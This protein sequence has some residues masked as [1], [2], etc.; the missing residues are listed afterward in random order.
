MSEHLGCEG[1]DLHELLVPQLAAHRAEDAGA[2]RVHLVV[3]EH[4]GVLVEADVAAVGTALLLLHADDD[5]LHDLALLDGRAGDGVLDGGDEDVADAGVAPLGAAEHADAEDLLG[6]AVVRD[7]KWR[8]SPA[9]S[10]WPAPG[11]L[12]GASAS[13]WTR[14]GSPGPAPCRRPW[15]RWPRRGRRASSCAP[16][17]SCRAG[18]ACGS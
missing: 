6:P 5:A 7:P 8:D 12:R 10:S 15:R 17:S 16:S 18:A 1:D 13:A 2:P 3:D 4:G 14:G 9:G 11:L